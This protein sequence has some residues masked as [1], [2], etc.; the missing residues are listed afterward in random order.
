MIAAVTFDFWGTLV[1]D[2][3][4]NIERQRQ[5]RIAGLA[6]LLGRAGHPLATA[7]VAA[8]Y[9]RSQVVLEERFW[10]RH[11]DLD[12]REQVRIVL[13][14]VAPGLWAQMVPAVFEEMV[15][16]YISPVLALPP[17]LSPG[18]GEAIEAL[19]ARGATLGIVSNTGRTPGLILRRVLERHDLLR[20]FR[21]ISYSDEVGHRKPGV[22]IFRRTLASAGADAAAAAHI[23]D[24]PLD[25]VTGAQGAGMR[26]IH[27]AAAG[28]PGAAHADMVVMHLADLPAALA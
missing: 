11:L 17:D 13:G 1:H 3:A 24:N 5:M 28:R 21:V 10:S 18:A 22:E 23:G 27:Y 12:H 9:D 14:C 8:A 19:R 25:D 6:D 15:Y 16:A 2:S 26:G 4:E 7:E 20:H